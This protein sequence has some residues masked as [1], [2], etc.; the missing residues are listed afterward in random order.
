MK[1]FILLLTLI[2]SSQL[3]IFAQKSK[4]NQDAPK[5]D[6]HVN[7]EY[8]EKGNLIKIDDYFN[9]FG[10]NKNDSI[11]SNS[12]RQSA[13]QNYPRSMKEMMK[14]MQQ[15]MKEMEEFQRKFFKE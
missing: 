3:A 5:E 1:R 11:S 4:S 13:K 10:M 2:L 9:N 12:Q 14:M 8:D 6:I 15:Q 7:R